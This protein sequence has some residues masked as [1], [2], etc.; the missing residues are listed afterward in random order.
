MT[1]KDAK[2]SVLIVWSPMASPAAP[3][4]RAHRLAAMASAAGRPAAVF[5]ANR[6]FYES[7]LAGANREAKSGGDRSSTGVPFGPVRQL[8]AAK[9]TAVE[10]APPLLAMLHERLASASERVA[11]TAF[12]CGWVCC[13]TL[14]GPAQVTAF[15]RD[16]GINPFVDLAEGDFDRRIAAGTFAAVVFLVADAVQC[17]AALTLAAAC[18]RADPALDRVLLASTE[19]AA[20]L[21]SFFDRTADVERPPGPDLLFELLPGSE[22]VPQ[23]RNGLQKESGP[24]ATAG[25][26]SPVIRWRVEEND[27]LPPAKKRKAAAADGC[28]N[29]LDL[30]DA[31][32]KEERL[33][34]PADLSA[35]HSFCWWKPEAYAPAGARQIWPQGVEGYTGVRPLPGAP[36]WCRVKDPVLLGVWLSAMTS[37]ELMRLRVDEHSGAVFRLGDAL[38][39]RFVPPAEL[40]PEEMDEVCSMVIAGGSVAPKWVRHNL[41]RSFLIGLVTERGVIAAN[42]SL[43]HPRREYIETVSRAAGIDLSG[44]LER[45]YT[46]VRP[47]YRG[48]GIGTRLLEGLTARARDYKIFSI[49]GE[50]NLATQKIAIRNRTRK[51]ATFYSHALEKPVGLWMP[52]QTA[53][54]IAADRKSK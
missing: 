45:G 10:Q 11:P 16:R 5:D 29:H 8:M 9:P 15:V 2:A 43:K 3:P 44:F 54:E 31:H 35:V 18:R 21:A 47:E 6:I 4:E 51:V 49:I 25:V 36:F 19:L 41:E 38:E 24:T 53:D 46:S 28:W 13:P 1:H 27:P 14:T 48:L 17:P 7:L 23:R 12:G 50:D 37:A 42:S 22:P 33:S 40:T 30:F 32:L 26:E 34:A 20:V 39:Y 52:E